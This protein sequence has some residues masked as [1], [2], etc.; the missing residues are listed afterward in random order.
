MSTNN[1]QHLT[2]GASLDEVRDL[3]FGSEDTVAELVDVP[4]W[5]VC[6]EVRSLTVDQHAAYMQV[7]AA[8]DDDAQRF[9]SMYPSLLSEAAFLPTFEGGEWV[10]LVSTTKVFRM[11]DAA[12]IMGRNAGAVTKVTRPIMRLSGLTAAEEDETEAKDEAPEDQQ[13]A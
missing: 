4:E 10:P 9:R 3:I 6:L 13:A 8:T 11:T 1:G 12:A 5:K 2:Q 7:M